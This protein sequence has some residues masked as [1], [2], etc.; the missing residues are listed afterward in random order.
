MAS[1][2]NK[3]ADPVSATSLAYPS[4]GRLLERLPAART[5]D[6][7][8]FRRRLA[9]IR[10]R[11]RQGKPVD[12]AVAAL[13]RDLT[14]SI[15]EVAAR[16]AEAPPRCYPSELPVSQRRD[17]LIEALSANQVVVVC[18]ETGSGK[19][20]QLPKIA[21][22]C[23]RGMR[24]M[25]GHTQ[26]RRLAARAVAAR[27]AEELGEPLGR[28]VGYKVRFDERLGPHPY[29][30]LMTD[31]I[32]LGETQG[33]PGLY[34]YDTLI[35][36]EAHE[37]SLN[38]DFLLGYLKRLLRQREDLKLVITSATIDPQRF[39]RHFDDAPVVE[40]SGRSYPVEIRYR[41]PEDQ[42]GDDYLAGI[43]RA[44]DELDRVG[45]G[46]ILV[47]LPGERDIRETADVL[48]RQQLANTE[49][50]PLYSRLA[51][52][53]QSLV[54]QAH[55]SRRI[56]LATNVAETSLTVPGIRYVI[57]PGLARINRYSY[58]TKV[59]RLP[60]EPVSQASADQRA[61]RCGRTGPG[62]CIRLYSEADYQERPRFTDPEIRRT[63]LAAVIL[64][65]KA[66][67]LGD[68]SEFPFIDPPDGRQV[69]DGL[70]L[71]QELGAIDAGARITSTGRLLARMPVDPRIGA[72]VA[73]GARNDCL[74]EVLIIAAALSIQDPRERPADKAGEAD[75]RQRRFQ[76]DVSDFWGFLLLW[77]WWRQEARTL[78]RR[79]RRR[80]CEA[81]FLAEARL[82]EWRDV[83]SELLALAH[84]FGWRVNRQ[85][86]SPQ[87]V[88]RA[89][90]AGL[91]G[92]VGT[93]T[94]AGDYQGPRGIRFAIHPGS[95]LAAKRPKWVVAAELV[96]TSRLFAR[97]VAPIDPQWVEAVGGDLVKRAYFEPHWEKKPAKVAAYEQ[98]S[99]Y[100][101]VLVA[102]RKVNYGAIDPAGAREIFIRHALV[103][104]EYD[105][106]GEFQRHNRSLIAELEEEEAKVR[107]RGLLVDEAVLFD[108]Y[109]RRLPEAIHDGA[110]FERW[111]KAAERA[112]P[113]LLF[114]DR[115]TLIREASATA[116]VADYPDAINV[117]G[118]DLKLSYHFSPGDEDDGVTATVPLAALNQ[119]P[120]AV[121]DWLVPGLVEEKVTQLIRGLPKALRRCFVP[122]PQFA[123]AV[124][125][126]A[127]TRPA[128]SD[129]RLDA[130]IGAELERMTGVRVTPQDWRPEALPAHLHMRFVVVDAD[131]AAMLSGRDLQALKAAL[132]ERARTAFE[133]ALG[134]QAGRERWERDDVTSWDFGP[135]PEKVEVAGSGSGLM[136]YPALDR[137]GNGVVLRLWDDPDAAAASHRA[138]VRQLMR[139]NLS[140][141]LKYIRKN[142]PYWQQMRRGFIAVGGEEVLREDFEQ[143]LIDDLFLAEPLPRDAVSFDTRLA[144]GRG[145]LVASANELARQVAEILEEYR[146]L[147][148][149][150]AEMSSGS[151]T[152]AVDDVRAQADGLV[153][154]G[155]ISATPS[156]W[157]PRL[158]VY[159]SA[160]R[161]RLHR[162]PGRLDKDN[163]GRE[164]I[165]RWLKRYQEAGGDEGAAENAS[166]ARLRWMLEEYRVSLFAQELGTAVRVSDKRL[167]ELLHG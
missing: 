147:Q 159:L 137:R 99:L 106:R 128:R 140:K 56:V 44:V 135:L 80:L 39:S 98:V 126:A 54:F 69:N 79:Q 163:R 14:R 161:R 107:R 55:S 45:R 28:S 41:P 53:H 97:G 15:D 92:H 38:I 36:D 6:L 75:R 152:P 116:G 145:R 111:R 18:G 132:G 35:I 127:G 89:L 123:R 141:E 118:V 17:E 113:G 114:L 1:Q 136:A 23:L 31:G 37:R 21:L 108:F 62:I 59:N 103:A 84:E 142:I 112:D 82:R 100:G 29:V 11:L 124:I 48:R 19:T 96:E 33:D 68:I 65:M 26:P 27:L 63:N 148:A 160:A 167:S 9:R 71:L 60:V 61:G 91:L 157:R 138:G 115:E 46:D 139:L 121:F 47:F 42:D 93:R 22:D 32:L 70:R 40:V 120:E 2:R 105:S 34:A 133:G 13:D 12:R 78:S 73:A 88:H 155:F 66:L 87:A 129:E 122:A 8:G 144:E 109:D 156:A 7:P 134:A 85:P 102:R 64:Q 83:H 58:R 50:L 149:D 101:L 95:A 76:S 25:I 153:Y 72:M 110:G 4:L 146:L 77:D 86:A 16:A 150:L 94:E 125:E 151:L 130:R 81:H 162:L 57:D 5:A 143:A 3:R 67:G 24:G 49:I 51:A 165:S 158:T 43:V 52:R 166:L 119:L 30:K 20:T 154:A 104:G 10:D 117:N 90:L 74:H 131:G 164:A